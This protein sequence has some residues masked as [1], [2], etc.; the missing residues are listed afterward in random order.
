MKSFAVPAIMLLSLL[1]A[2]GNGDNPS[3]DVVGDLP[4]GVDTIFDTNPGDTGSDS[5]MDEGSGDAIDDAVD[6]AAD[7]GPSDAQTDVPPEIWYP[8]VTPPLPFGAENRGYVHMNGI[9]H[10]HSRWSHDGCFPDHEEITSPEIE[11]C[12]TTYV[13]EADI[14][15]CR[16]AIIESMLVACVDEYRLAA[17][18]AGMEFLFQ[19]DHP[20]DVRDQTFENALHYRPDS[21]DQMVLDA[22]DRQVANRMKC[23]AESPVDHVFVYFGTEGSKQMPIGMAAPIPDIVFNTSFED[24]TPLEQAQAAL[25]AVH[26]QGGWGLVCHPEQKDLSVQRI[27]E[28]PLDLIEIFNL[29]PALMGILED[30]EI[31]FQLDRF[32]ASDEDA[33]NPD[34]AMMLV[35]KPV[36]NDPLKF[37]ESVKSIRLGHILATDIHRNVELPAL[38]ES[39]ETCGDNW[40]ETYPNLARLLAKGGPAILG[41]GDRFD[42]YRRSLR[43]ASNHA[44][45]SST[46]TDY[47]AIRDAVGLGRSYSAFDI[48]G[49][50]QGFDFFAVVDGAALEMG[51]EATGYT[52]AKIYFRTPSITK[53]LWATERFS[54]PADTEIVTKLIKIDADG[55]SRV[56]REVIG[57]GWTFEHVVDGPAVYRIEVWMTPKHLATDLGDMAWVADKQ[58]P[59]IYSNALFF[60]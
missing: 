36:V 13:E 21:G 30:F 57:Q 52:D 41:D 45:V 48:M 26:A 24:S 1:V 9:V 49:I 53:P 38:C 28:L 56:V 15:A 35:L 5:V 51:Q 14:N 60:R 29:H 42:S 8:P 7:N 25:A 33:P 20:G 59:W 32:M 46:G 44:L 10:L 39:A 18:A 34:L 23:P 27:V 55:G 58:Y 2:C 37:D 16:D 4:V 11:A 47:L 54:D 22:Q 50:P 3:V 12:S 31:L 17:C 6:D 40:I 19:T 43:W